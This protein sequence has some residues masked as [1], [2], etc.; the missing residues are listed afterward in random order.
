MEKMSKTKCSYNFLSLYISVRMYESTF[1]SSSLTS[2]SP[3]SSSSIASVYYSFRFIT[4]YFFL[5]PFESAHSFLYDCHSLFIWL[6]FPCQ[7]DGMNVNFLPSFWYCCILFF[8]FRSTKWKIE[9]LNECLLLSCN[10][11]NN[12]TTSTAKQRKLKS[13]WKKF[14]NRKNSENEIIE[15]SFCLC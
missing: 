14:N 7:T 2:S 15:F 13:S 5:A 6:F 1:F 10:N 3:S 11:N 8:F 9:N 12:N 4:I